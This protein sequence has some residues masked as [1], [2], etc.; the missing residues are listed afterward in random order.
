M[1]ERIR[2]LDRLRHIL[3]SIE[4]IDNYL[5]GKTYEEMKADAMRYHAVVYNMMIIGEAAN[6]LTKEFRSEHA[7]VPWRDMVDMRNLLIHGYIT[8]NAA[9]I[10]DTYT[11][12]LPVLRQ[13]I[14][15]YIA[16]MEA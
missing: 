10:W 14:E 5:R 1:R 8:T 9:Y 3:E 13:Q 2:D 6:L 16:K 12:D 4:H 7:E 15:Q 11:D